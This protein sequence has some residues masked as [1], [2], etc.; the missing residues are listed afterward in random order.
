M[1][2]SFIG[3]GI[4][5]IVASTYAVLYGL[6]GGV[7]TLIGPVLGVFCR[8]I[9]FKLSDID[10]LKSYWPILLGIILLLVV[11]YKP[12]VIRFCNNW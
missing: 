11:V 2:M 6:F 5:G 4:M 1:H 3:A 9:K 7:G 8:G 12:S 10:A